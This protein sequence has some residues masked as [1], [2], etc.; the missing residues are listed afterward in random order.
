VISNKKLTYDFNKADPVIPLN[1]TLNYYNAVTAEIPDVHSHYRMFE[2]PGVGHCYG[3]KGSQPMTT[4]DAL[5]A[6]VENGTVP[7]TLPVSFK[8]DNG[9]M[10]SRF[11]CPYP[12]KV[13]Y[14]GKGDT[15]VESSYSCGL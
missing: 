6:W 4:F 15:T 5:R 13:I 7:E 11:L 2:A 3:G 8:D 14:D 9:T 10:N 12:K 1:G